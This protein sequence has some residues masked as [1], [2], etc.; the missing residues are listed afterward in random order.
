MTNENYIL[1]LSRIQ[2]EAKKLEEQLNIINNQIKE[3][4]ILK[5]SL[6][7]IDK[8]KNENFLASLGKGVF[9]ETKINNK[10]LFVNV[11]NNIVLKK[12]VKETNEI[13]D[14][15]IKEL[16]KIKEEI[17]KSI[18]NLNIELQFLVEEAQKKN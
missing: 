17:E 15:Q 13:I 3:F 9:I 14:K 8:T 7:N 10:E 5:E 16:N 6:D 18:E 12:N 2:E 4:E 1:Q 11:G